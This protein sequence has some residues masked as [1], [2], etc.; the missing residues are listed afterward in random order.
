MSERPSHSQEATLAIGQMHPAV[1]RLDHIWVIG[2]WLLFDWLIVSRQPIWILV[3]QVRII[4][5][6]ITFSFA[7]QDMEVFPVSGGVAELR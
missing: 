6:S 4:V 7:D 3:L 5:R 1:G 2:C